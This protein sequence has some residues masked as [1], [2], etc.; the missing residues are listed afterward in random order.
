MSFKTQLIIN[1]LLLLMLGLVSIGL[2]SLSQ[3]T[4]ADAMAQ[5]KT[6]DGIV[7][8]AS[9]LALLAHEIA[10][11]GH[12]Q[13]S[14]MQWKNSYITLQSFLSEAAAS[15]EA[16]QINTEALQW[17]LDSLAK[18]YGRLEQFVDDSET[19]TPENRPILAEQKTR[20]LGQ[21]HVV[22]HSLLDQ[23]MQLRTRYLGTMAESV[24]K[25]YYGEVAFVCVSIVLLIGF[26]LILVR[27]AFHD[28]KL[29][30]EKVARVA[31]G[32]LNTRIDLKSHNELSDFAATFDYMTDSLAKTMA[33]RKELESIVR[34]RTDALNE[35]R[36]AAISVMEDAN[37]QRDRLKEATAALKEA[38]ESAEKANSAKSIFLANMSHEIR[39]PMNVVMGMVYLLKQTPLD[40]T[41]QSYLEKTDIAAS[42]LLGIINDI[43]DFSKIEAGKMELE[44]ADFELEDLIAN[45]SGIMAHKAAEKG[46]EFV[47]KYDFD[48]PSAL[49]GDSL[50]LGQ[51]LLNLCSNAIKFTQEGEIVLDISMPPEHKA[52]EIT[53]RFCVRDSGIGI[54]K[55]QQKKLFR[56]FS[57]VDESTTRKFGGTG[58]GLA[59]SKKLVY[60]MNGRIWLE[61]SEPN[62]GST[63]CFSVNLQIQPGKENET[64]YSHYSLPKHTHTLRALVIEDNDASG[65]AISHMLQ[66]FGFESENAKDAPEG[67]NRLKSSPKPFDFVF[68]DWS[69]PQ[70][71]GLET[72]KTIR[73]LPYL[74]DRPKLI[75]TLESSSAVAQMAQGVCDGYLLKPVSPSTLFNA[76]SSALGYSPRQASRH[77]VQA[78]SLEPIRGASIL[79]VEDNELNQDFAKNLL[80][81][82]G[83]VV[84]LAGDGYQAIEKYRS[85]VYDII[86]MD[87]QM[88]GIDGLEATRRIRELEKKGETHIPIIA[89]TAHALKEY[90]DKALA[91][92]MEDQVT[93]P[94]DPELLFSKLLQWIPHKR[95]DRAVQS[96]KEEEPESTVDFSVFEGVIDTRAGLKR[97]AGSADDYIKALIT[98]KNRYSDIFKR[99]DDL[100]DQKRIEDARSLCHEIKGVSGNIGAT[101]L[102]AQCR[103][104]E[105]RYK[106]DTLPS[107]EERK[108]FAEALDTVTEKIEA[109]EKTQ[110]QVQPEVPFNRA[111]IVEQ[112]QTMLSSF[113]VDISNVNKSSAAIAP[114]LRHS[115]YAALFNGITKAL[116]RFDIDTARA[117]TRQL[118]ES[119]QNSDPGHEEKP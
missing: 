12:E 85:N 27:R 22:T 76:V 70:N 69:L 13:R 89:M 29:I 21:L 83:F 108:A 16:G 73:T 23:A 77:R 104:L 93:K 17:E 47:V 9:Q 100:V 64:L 81:K 49:I 30:K 15:P 68:L 99:I 2:M 7:R 92:G 28:L 118:S 26:L 34:E 58:L 88:P 37:L 98:F 66:M 84:D 51:V 60:L 95:P 111:F 40:G 25:I 101:A 96:F 116:E 117:N 32:D 97:M 33:S 20:L 114:M 105:E 3:R 41:Q 115:R 90:R 1:I 113:D 72:A 67:I 50:R 87:I 48:I 43:L 10:L 18:I 74:S 75:F 78:L 35:S 107:S 106:D 46:V 102:F 65:M 45:T 54:S 14:R 55:E 80:S 8:H 56:E 38:K 71:D 52:D 62:R 6:F 110:M 24:E 39:T 19:V 4:I 31:Q 5:Q 53:L 86:L 79:V 63:F 103:S 61:S 42:S 109:F 82:S 112:L 91:S 36:L 119:L 11:E 59:I 94:I 57:Q 44:R